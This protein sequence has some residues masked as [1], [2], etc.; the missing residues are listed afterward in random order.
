TLF[1]A[2]LDA[3]IAATKG[4]SGVSEIDNRIWMHERATHAHAS[5]FGILP[6]KSP[7][8]LQTQRRRK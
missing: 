1:P 3:T 4:S 6:G 8:S 2:V 7:E 5:K